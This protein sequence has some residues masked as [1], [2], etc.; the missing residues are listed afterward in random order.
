M[1]AVDL[2]T[3]SRLTSTKRLSQ[4]PHLPPPP[5][6]LFNVHLKFCCPKRRKTDIHLHEDVNDQY[7]HNLL[8]M[9]RGR[10]FIL[11][12][13]LSLSVLLQNLHNCF[14]LLILLISCYF[15]VF[16]GQGQ[17]RRYMVPI[18]LNRHIN[19]YQQTNHNF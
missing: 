17:N 1:G 8:L 4:T 5:D 10:N 19:Q 3:F 16:R 12:I 6:P 15:R 14:F 2:F 18:F 11:R 13:M 9:K 7:H